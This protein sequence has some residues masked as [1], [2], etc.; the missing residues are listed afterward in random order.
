MNHAIV[1]IRTILLGYAAAV[2]FGAM[3][4]VI[5]SF[6]TKLKRNVI[7]FTD[8]IRPVSAISLF[9]V[10]IYFFGLGE[11]SR[12][13][14]ISWVAWPVI[15]LNTIIGA[16]NVDHS[17]IDAAMLDGANVWKCFWIVRIPMAIDN[18]MTGLRTGMGAAWIS[19]TAAEMIGSNEGLGFYILINSQVFDYL[20]MIMGILAVAS[21]GFVMN[22]ILKYIHKKTRW[23][24]YEKDG[25]VRIRV[26]PCTPIGYGFR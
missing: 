8:F 10:F 24:F 26:V 25:N 2:L 7:A 14:I 23:L 1:S 17:Q 15:Y 3:L 19:L 21:I 20:R 12:T 16:E 18:I 5:S 9:P 13:V 6:G 11:L 22:T 4:V